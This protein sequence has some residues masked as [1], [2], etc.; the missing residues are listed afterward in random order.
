MPM[1]TPLCPSNARPARAACGQP[2]ANGTP[3]PS[4]AEQ[5]DAAPCDQTQATE[6]AQ[7]EPDG[8]TRLRGQLA[9]GQDLWVFGY[10]SLIWRPEFQAVE[11]HR[12]RVLGWHRALRM[13]S[14]VNRGSP[15]R[16][17]LVFALLPGGSCQG[18]VWRIAAEEAQDTLGRL[19][20][21]EMPLPVYTPR[22]LPC[23]TPQGP[24]RALAFTLSRTHPSHT[25]PLSDQTYRE[26]FAHANGRFG[27]T[28]D[29]ARETQAALRQHGIEDRALAALLR[30]AEPPDKPP[31]I[32]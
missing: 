20:A 29:Y 11:Q 32:L 5:S 23:P 25:G 31:P 3:E 12:T 8:L 13:W 21:R 10:A 22:W 24:V 17:G 9:A 7:A 30:L 1:D 26:I 28:L 4:S 6:T 18:L 14:R 27:T 16:P 15:E 2:G 19:W